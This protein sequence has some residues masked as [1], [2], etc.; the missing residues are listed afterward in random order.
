[1]EDLINQTHGV[2]ISCRNLLFFFTTLLEQCIQFYLKSLN[3]LKISKNNITAGTVK[4]T[5]KPTKVPDFFT[6][7]KFIVRNIHLF[8][9]LYIFKTITLT[10]NHLV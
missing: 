10:I 1:M 2:E 9:P 7:V 8:P 3:S 6:D 4:R 5:V